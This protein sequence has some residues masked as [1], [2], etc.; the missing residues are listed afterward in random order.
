ML[1]AATRRYPRYLLPVFNSF[2][3]VYACLALLVERHF[4]LTYGGGF[5]ENFYG[6]KRER[7]LRVNGGELPRAQQGASKIVRETLKLHEH[8]VWKN[9]AVMV[10]LPYLKR[11][12]DESYDIHISQAAVLGRR[13]QRDSLPPRATIRQRILHYYKWF[14]RHVYPSV[15]AAYY[16]SLLAFQLLYLFDAS[17]FH[18]PFLCLIRM[19]MRRVG[20]A[21]VRAIEEAEAART[22]PRPTPATRPGQATSLFAPHIFNNVVY[23]R[24]LSSLRL[25][26]P[27]SIFAL[28]FLEWWHASDFARKLSK[29]ASEGLDL[30][31]P[32]VAGQSSPSKPAQESSRSDFPSSEKAANLESAPIKPSPLLLPRQPPISA[33]THLPILTVLPSSSTSSSSC[34]ICLT[35][36]VTPTA[37]QT[38]YVFCYTCIFRWIDGS[39]DRQKAFMEGGRGEE[40]WA[41]EEGSREGKW[42]SG[43]GRCAVTGRRVLGGTDGLRRVMV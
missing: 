35:Q 33:S 34:P 15:H 40:G 31:P 17:K 24:L 30:P 22:K 43:K 12:L 26:L 38:G 25:L 27:A 3:E 21:D 29:K 7:V 23:P 10:G 8:D 4:L 20:A 14:L 41:E 42:E 1:A 9:L 2:D 16:F 19:R 39:H 11:K 13:Y 28:K 36:T 37:C 5:T 32:I 6:L 18:S